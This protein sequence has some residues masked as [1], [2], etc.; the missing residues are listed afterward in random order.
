[1]KIDIFNSGDEGNDVPGEIS[2]KINNGNSNKKRYH[3]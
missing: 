2:F 1:M 3:N